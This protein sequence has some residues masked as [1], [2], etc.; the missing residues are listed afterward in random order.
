MFREIAIVFLL[1]TGTLFMFIAALG[2]VRMPDLYTRMSASTKASTLGLGLL[3]AAA[4]LHFGDITSI[5]HAIGTF[6]FVL[7]TAPVAAHLLGRAGYI[8]GARLWEGTI[9]DDLKGQ[10]DPQAQRLDHFDIIPTQP[11]E[12]DITGSD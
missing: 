3:L 11:Y 7:L 5:T 1:I 10:Y 6:L 12:S 8:K 4:G 2:L 9:Q